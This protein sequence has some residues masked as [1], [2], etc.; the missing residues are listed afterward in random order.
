MIALFRRTRQIRARKNV[1]D[2]YDSA[3]REHARLAGEATRL[4]E[5]AAHYQALITTTDPSLYNPA[6]P[7]SEQAWHR[8]AALQDA[9][10]EIRAEQ[11]HNS[12]LQAA[13]GLALSRHIDEYMTTHHG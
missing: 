11:L 5:L 9:V 4:A 6:L 13:A 12:E 3:A 2:S 10:H 1:Q 8:Y 7:L